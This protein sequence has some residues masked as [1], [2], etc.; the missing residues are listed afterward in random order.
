MH[1]IISEEV[2]RVDFEVVR[3][4]ESYGEII[5]NY[6]SYLTDESKLSHQGAE[7]LFF[8]TTEAELS[9]ILQEMAKRC[10]TVNFS[11]ARTGI[12]G[13]AVPY[14]GEIVSIEKLDQVMGL[15]YDR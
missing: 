12:V 10:I 5:K 14:G 4:V 11:G 13:G 7:Y 1:E 6:S 15:R 9:A 3:R 8:P 2:P